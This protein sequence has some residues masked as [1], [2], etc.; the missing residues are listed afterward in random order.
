M[1]AAIMRR[2]AEVTLAIMKVGRISEWRRAREAWRRHGVKL[3]E[4]QNERYSAGGGVRT[5]CWRCLR[6]A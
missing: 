1:L 4:N 5:A 3:S 2:A 6:E